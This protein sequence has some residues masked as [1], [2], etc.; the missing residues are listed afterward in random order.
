MIGASVLATT[1]LAAGPQPGPRE[2]WSQGEL[3][4]RAV[5]HHA[6]VGQA[7]AIHAG[8]RAHADDGAARDGLG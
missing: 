4:V 5:D 1:L 7:R 3:V 8:A 6:G 2:A